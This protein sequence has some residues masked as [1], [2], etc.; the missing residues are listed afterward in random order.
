YYNT[1]S[2]RRSAWNLTAG[3]DSDP[4]RDLFYDPEQI[5]A[6]PAFSRN[7]T[8]GYRKEN[9]RK[10]WHYFRRAGI[11]RIHGHKGRNGK[12]GGRGG[13]DFC[14]RSRGCV[15]DVADRSSGLLYSV[16]GSNPGSAI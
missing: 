11:D 7:D 6:I 15:L 16:C 12:P 4:V 9:E 5:H 10:V 13:S 1:P 8:G 3:D 14:R 2:G